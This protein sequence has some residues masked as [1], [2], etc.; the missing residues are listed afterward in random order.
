MVLATED[1]AVVKVYK[2]MMAE[3]DTT[4]ATLK[5]RLKCVEQKKDESGSN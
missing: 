3:V 2:R 5:A 4:I 1:D